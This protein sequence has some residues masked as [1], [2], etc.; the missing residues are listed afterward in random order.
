V[1]FDET[2]FEF[3]KSN[4]ASMRESIKAGQAH[5][6]YQGILCVL[7]D[8]LDIAANGGDCFA[9]IGL[10]KNRDAMLLTV[11]D[12]SRKAYAGGFSLLEISKD[13]E[14]LI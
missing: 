12:G 3:S 1:K 13:A 8:V 14:K 11:K 10:T 9:T 4:L 5:I 6:A 2:K 7:A